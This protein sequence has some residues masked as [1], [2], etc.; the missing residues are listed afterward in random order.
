VRRGV[1]A[2]E[3]AII[4]RDLD[5]LRPGGDLRSTPGQCFGAESIPAIPLVYWEICIDLN[6]CLF[7]NNTG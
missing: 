1:Q 4:P 2:P 5:L 7:Q 3:T 6:F